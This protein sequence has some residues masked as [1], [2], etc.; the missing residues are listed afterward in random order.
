MSDIFFK[1]YKTNLMKI[2]SDFEE[3][4]EYFSSSFIYKLICIK[5]DEFDNC[6][7]KEMFFKQLVSSNLTISNAINEDIERYSISIENHQ[8]IINQCIYEFENVNIIND[9]ILN[10]SKMQYSIDVIN[11]YKNKGLPI[12]I[13]TNF[14][15][16]IELKYNERILNIIKLNFEAYKVEFN[17]IEILTYLDEKTN[18]LLNDIELAKKSLKNVSNYSFCLISLNQISDKIQ[19]FYSEKTTKNN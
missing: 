8:K 9:F 1:S 6:D 16:D 5:Q 11:S 4:G 3:K 18:F 17:S 2:A 13:E 14:G 7:D 15:N 10:Y 12:K 19:D